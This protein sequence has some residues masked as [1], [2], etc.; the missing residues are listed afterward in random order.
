M[1]MDTFVRCGGA[2]AILAGVLRAAASFA[3]DSEVEQQVLYLIVDLLLLLG[4]FAAYA[5]NHEALAGGD[6]SYHLETAR[7][8]K[9][10]RVRIPDHVQGGRPLLA[11]ETNGVFDQQPSNAVPPEMW[12]DKQAVEVHRE[13]VTRQHGG[14]SDDGAI[15]LGDEHVPGGDLIGR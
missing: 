13:T 15:P 3:W 8:V 12:L 5:Q 2:A 7:P 4:V 6:R 11:S 10:F 9:R 1:R 14:E